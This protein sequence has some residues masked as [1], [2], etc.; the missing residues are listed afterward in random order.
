MENISIGIGKTIVEF[1]SV[2]MVERVCRY[3]KKSQES[4]GPHPIKPNEDTNVPIVIIKNKLGI[5]FLAIA[6]T[7]WFV[8]T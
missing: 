3:L 8:R 7:T 2:E 4:H 6:S 1:F 5:P